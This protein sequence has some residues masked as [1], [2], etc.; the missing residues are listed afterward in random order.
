MSYTELSS[1]TVKCR[2]PHRCVWCGELIEA[3]QYAQYTVGVCDNDFQT[4]YM[5]PECVVALPFADLDDDF[6]S[7]GEFARGT[8]CKHG[9]IDITTTQ[10]AIT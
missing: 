6:F 9:T 1:K 7:A 4:D 5:H 3:G 2:K 10:G 8:T